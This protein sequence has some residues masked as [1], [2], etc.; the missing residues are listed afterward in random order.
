SPIVW[1]DR[2]FLTTATWPM[3]LTEKERRAS[4]AEH[5]VPCFD[6]KDG[7]QLWDT[8]VPT[9]KIVVNNFYHGYTV[10]TPATDG[11]LVFALFG[12]GI[13]ATLDFDGKIVWREE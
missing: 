5:H 6:T 11:R 9:G 10:P 2:I 3:G 1:R 7:T 13:L 12:S 8:V 4:I